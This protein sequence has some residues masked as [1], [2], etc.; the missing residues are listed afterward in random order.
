M[1]GRA[2]PVRLGPVF[3]V[4][5]FRGLFAAQVLSLLGDQFARVALMV[6]VFNRTGSALLSGAVYALG[7]LPAVLGGPLLSGLA[8][9]YPHRLV[10]IGADVVR[11]VLVVAMALWASVF[12]VLCLLLVAV[13]LL[14]APF[15]AARA[16]LLMQVLPSQQ[17]LAGS[18]VGNITDQ[19]AQVL[20]FALG[21]GV[22]A[23]VGPHT[24]LLVDAGTFL[25]SA[26][27]LHATV[28][29]RPTVP[30]RHL[31][32][33][34]MT[35]GPAGVLRLLFADRWLR[36]LVLLAL[37]CAFYVVPEGLAGPYA[38]ALGGGPGLV[39]LVMA[40]QP[41]GAAVGAVLL[42][43]LAGPDRRLTVMP[44]LAVLAPAALVGCVLTDQAPIVLALLVL[45]GLG[46][47]YQLIANA[48]FMTAVPQ[49]MRGRAFGYVRAGII[50]VQGVAF[51]LAGTLAEH[52]EPGTVI[53][54]AGGIGTAAAVLA[55]ANCRAAHPS[56][57]ERNP[58]AGQAPPGQGLSAA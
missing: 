17:Y 54:A 38:S 12:V 7:F 46:T 20:G 23:A 22:V 50:A 11:A 45:S 49:H 19:G 31:P 51:L 40:A 21:G 58:P 47:A 3:E 53:A 26:A 32:T 41:V 2:S 1:I 56:A 13:E 4:R 42:V 30:G 55:A 29:S 57:A 18:A 28:V 15:S 37:L 48:A 24:A 39:G 33:D 44:P 10:M 5:A 6:L 16:A 34:P 35:A 14:A 27:L 43:R 8:D 36:S 25:A 52:A 9:R